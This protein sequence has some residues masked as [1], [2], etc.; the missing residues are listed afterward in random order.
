MV[1]IN[2]CCHPCQQKYSNMEIFPKVFFKKMP[3]GLGIFKWVCMTR[4]RRIL[5]VV[6]INFCCHPCQQKYSNMEIFPIQDLDNPQGGLGTR[7]ESL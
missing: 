6:L 5:Y 3:D 2:F 4:N 7:L 1:L